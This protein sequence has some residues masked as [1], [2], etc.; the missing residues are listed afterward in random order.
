MGFGACLIGG[1]LD[2]VGRRQPRRLVPLLHH[3]LPAPRTSAAPPPPRTNRT[4]RVPHPVLIGHAA[5]RTPATGARGAPGSRYDAF[6]SKRPVAL[7][8]H[9]GQR[10]PLYTSAPPGLC[11][12]SAR[13]SAPED[14]RRGWARWPACAQ[15]GSRP[16]SRSAHTETRSTPQRSTRSHKSSHKR[17]TWSHKSSHKSYS[18][19]PLRLR[20]QPGAPPRRAPVR[21][22]ATP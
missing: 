14:A 4:R 18:V 9:R 3:C 19:D 13:A 22:R 15:R 8:P 12:P 1:G 11:A 16:G 5:S 21:G 6:P 10:T 20:A 2:R 7:H 17:S